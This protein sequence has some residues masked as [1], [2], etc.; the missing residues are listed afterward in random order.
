MVVRI[1]YCGSCS[2]MSYIRVSTTAGKTRL[3]HTT[4]SPIVS[5][6]GGYILVGK[7]DPLRRPEPYVGFVSAFSQFVT[8]VLHNGTTATVRQALSGIGD[9]DWKVL[10][11][12]MPMVHRIFV[13]D[14]E[15]KAQDCHD[16]RQQRQPDGALRRF[17]YV[18]STFLRAISSLG[19]PLV[20]LLD[21]VQYADQCSLRVLMN[22]VSDLSNCPDL[23]VIL[24]Y[25]KN[26]DQVVLHDTLE[27]ISESTP[28]VTKVQVGNLKQDDVCHFLAE[29]LQLKCSQKMKELSTLVYEQTK[30]N[31][32]Y[33][34]EFIKFLLDD[35]LLSLSNEGWTYDM[36][37]I[38]ITVS[39]CHMSDFL[40]LKLESLPAELLQFLKVA[41]CCGTHVPVHLLRCIFADLVCPLLQQASQ[42][43]LLLKDHENEIYAFPHDSIQQAAYGMIPLHERQQFHLEIGRRM[44]NTMGADDLDRSIY[45]LI[46]QFLF[47]KDLVKDPKECCNLA[48]LCL[49]AGRKAASSSTFRTAC[50]Y[51]NLGI[52]FLGNK[53]WRDEY[54]LCL[55]LHTAAAEMHLCST[56]FDA[57]ERLV[58]VVLKEA[59]P[60]DRIQAETT[61]LY[62]M[63]M[64]NKQNEAI[65]FGLELLS[66]FGEKFPRRLCRARVLFEAAKVRRLLR[67]KT[68]EELLCLPAM[69]D[70]QKLA[71]VQ[72]LH[73]IFLHT[74]L[75]RP[76]LTP[77][78][79]M[80]FMSLTLRDG[81]CLLSPQGFATYGML[82]CQIGNFDEAYRFGQLG[83]RM[84]ELS[85]HDEALPR[86]YAAFYGVV[87]SIRRPNSEAIEKLLEGHRIGL[88]TG[89]L[90]FAC[91][92]ANLYVYT[93]MEA[94]M[95]L[96][97]VDKEFARMKSL[98]K[99]LGQETMLRFNMPCIQSIH[100][101]MGL[102]ED[103]LASEGDIMDFEEIYQWCLA[104]NLGNLATGICIHRL[105]LFCIFNDFAGAQVHA[106]RCLDA[107][108]LM[109]TS[110]DVAWAM[111]FA[112]ICHLENANRGYWSKLKSLR[113]VRK[114]HSILKKLA[115][116]CPANFSHL[117][118]FVEAEIAAYMGRSAEAYERYSCAIS[119]AKSRKILFM[120]AFFT[121][122]CGRFLHKNLRMEEARFYVDEACRVYESWGGMA[123]VTRLRKEIQVLFP[124]RVSDCRKHNFA[125]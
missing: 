24:T 68:D 44:W 27:Q 117:R 65:D 55:A 94:G 20:L 16:D 57:M 21:D 120:E 114:T 13:D 62:A 1:P 46:S 86:V 89:D 52:E 49:L 106:E 92:N 11:G 53:G 98:M 116:S 107:V 56:D 105:M 88:Q 60:I 17:A 51:L 115:L 47:A 109:P 32:F 58:D 102:T 87:H 121:E 125:A 61:R 83:V 10:T 45:V 23:F 99:S 33:I 25:A 2:I 28:N 111:M 73:L 39:C 29:A 69:K 71:C 12:M 72:I 14:D 36:Q 43:G 95:P 81:Q 42:L 7:Y 97:L 113:L 124:V 70:P 91:L 93:S 108:S 41:S 34:V 19:K 63:G 74:L 103:P 118:M 75:A 100:H 85:G 59:R 66:R 80:K 3:V 9:Q 35:K 67:E 50:I 15:T 110:D 96:P 30:G 26:E 79:T 84:V 37:E 5:S 40:T 22:I 101:Y 4:L 48:Q 38:R 31:L 64:V 18:F 8:Q 112:T 82:L 76:K 119:C 78:V 6:L 122:R 77:F 123:K 90:E 104:N 54:E